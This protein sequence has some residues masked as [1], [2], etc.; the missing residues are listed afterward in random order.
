M[1]WVVGVWRCA[2]GAKGPLS[3]IMMQE[4]RAASGMYV[5]TYR[6]S[7]HTPLIDHD[8]QR[9]LLV[10]VQTSPC[11]IHAYRLPACPPISLAYRAPSVHSTPLSCPP[12]PTS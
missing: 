3:G 5:Q 4:E 1:E 6:P 9:Q 8:T 2:E 12:C 11:P 7:S 10:K